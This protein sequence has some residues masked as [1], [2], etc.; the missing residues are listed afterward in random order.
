MDDYLSKPVRPE[1]MVAIIEEWIGGADKRKKRPEAQGVTPGSDAPAIDMTVI[2]NLR[3]LQAGAKTNLLG[4][5]IETFRTDSEKKI[6]AMR[7]AV[8][9]RDAEAL[10]HAAHA[11]K[12]GSGIVGANRM[13]SL[14]DIIE[15]ISRSGSTEGALPLI[16]TVEEEF[17]R[18][19]RALQVEKA[20]S[21]DQTF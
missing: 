10:S 19:S 16:T 18:A 21:A 9:N 15:K 5:L 13:A 20:N 6:A 2:S 11:L 3:S 8:D 12:G 17:G 4:E 1:D 14:C 7:A